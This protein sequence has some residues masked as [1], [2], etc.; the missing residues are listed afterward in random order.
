MPQSW[1]RAH[2]IMAFLFSKAIIE[3]ATFC[4]ADV[5]KVT[6]YILEIA[7]EKVNDIYKN[8]RKIK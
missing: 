3:A 2:G 5:G 4:K 8:E 6:E 7:K 1:Q